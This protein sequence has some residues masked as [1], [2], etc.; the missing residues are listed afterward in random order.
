MRERAVVKVLR[1]LCWRVGFEDGVGA[2][3]EARG[4]GWGGEV[5]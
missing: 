3:T 4:T 5:L 2:G 1:A